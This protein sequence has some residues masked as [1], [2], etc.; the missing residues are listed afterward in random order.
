MPVDCAI[1]GMSPG[2]NS[3]L[4]MTWMMPLEACTSA[5]VTLAPSTVT[6]AVV[7]PNLTLSLLTVVASMPSLRS[8]DATSPLMTW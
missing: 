5:M 8:V 2:G 4:S 7:T 6:P 1:A 3:T